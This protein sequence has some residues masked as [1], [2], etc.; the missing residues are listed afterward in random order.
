MPDPLVSVVI[1][2]FNG[3]RFLSEA[4]ESV[5]AQDYEPFEVVFVDDGSTDATPEIARRYQVSYIRQENAGLAAARNTGWAETRGELVT[6]F[7]DDDLMPPDRLTKQARVLVENPDIGCVLGRQEWI[8]APDWLPRDQVFGDPAGIPF[9][10][11]MLRREALEKVGGFDSTFRYA[12]DRDLLVRL[13][14]AGVG[15]EVLP[16]VVLHRRYHGENMTAPTNRPT[17]HPLTRSLKA[18]LARDRT[19]EERTT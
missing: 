13:R 10:A 11:A 16:E 15:I 6:F 7:D 3:E 14:A 5:F 9:A 1:A 4:L 12:E 2:S 18:K 17:V 19:G 8:D